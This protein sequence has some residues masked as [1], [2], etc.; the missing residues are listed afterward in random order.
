[1]QQ[2]LFHKIYFYRW[3]FANGTSHRA[4]QQFLFRKAENFSR[5]F[6]FYLWWIPEKVDSRETM[7]NIK[8]GLS[9]HPCDC[10]HTLKLSKL[11]V[12]FGFLFCLK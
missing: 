6:S 2:V 11:C 4:S 9:C 12:W 1:M 10:L 7:K 3:T 5:K 8:L